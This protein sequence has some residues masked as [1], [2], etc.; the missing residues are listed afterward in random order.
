VAN[1]DNATLPEDTQVSVPVLNNDSD[2]DGILNPASVTIIDPPNHGTATVNPAN[3]VITYIP[4]LE[5]VGND[6]LLYAVCDNG[7]PILCDTAAVYFSVTATSVRLLAKIRLQGAVFGSPDTLMRDNLR[8]LG[9]VPKHEPYTALGSPF[10][11]V[12]GGGN[13]IIVDTTTVFAN[14]GKNSIVDWVFVELRNPNVPGQVV[15]TRCALLQRDGDVV[16]IDGVSPLEF[17]NTLPAF[18]Y[19]AIRHRN[20]LGTMT[21]NAIIMTNSGTTIDFTNLNT[22]LWDDGTGL[23]GYEQ[24]T[25]GGKY[26]MWAGNVNV[27]TSVVFAGQNN[28]KDPIFNQVDQAPGNFLH[29]QSY[30]FNGYLL[31]D[32][33]LDGHAIFAGQGNDVDFIFNN[34]DGHPRNLTRSQSYVIRQQLP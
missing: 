8:I 31:G 6:T 5:F 29:S 10:I 25:V 17:E 20:H 21:A 28:D 23:D 33:N 1:N 18:Y 2:V 30:V 4:T 3:G 34:V 27:N 26:A 11:N 14:H 13:E 16:D 24:A 19:V 9:R 12:N 32:V 22:P 15:A 7:T